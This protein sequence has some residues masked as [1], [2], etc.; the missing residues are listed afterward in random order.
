MEGSN[1]PGWIAL[2]TFAIALGTLVRT[3]LLS[4]SDDPH[5]EL[6]TECTSALVAGSTLG[7]LPRLFDIESEIVRWTITGLTLVFAAF[8]WRQLLRAMRLKETTAGHDG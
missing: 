4:G 3:R 7:S 6:L 8:A 1:L 5:N 2:A